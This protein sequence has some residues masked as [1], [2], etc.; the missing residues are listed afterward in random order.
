[1]D[2]R[3]MQDRKD[4]ALVTSRNNEISTMWNFIFQPQNLTSFSF[5]LSFCRSYKPETRVS[6]VAKIFLS[7]QRVDSIF[8]KEK[9]FSPSTVLSFTTHEFNSLT[10]L[11]RRVH[12]LRRTSTFLTH[13]SLVI[14]TFSKRVRRAA[15]S[16]SASACVVIF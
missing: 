4:L 9:V 10:V 2:T 14:L 7:S 8:S 15:T 3:M 13:S 11:S 6:F 12:S 1:M 5:F 16:A